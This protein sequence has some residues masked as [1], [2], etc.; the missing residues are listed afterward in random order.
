MANRRIRSP[1]KSGAPARWCGNTLGVLVCPSE[2]LSAIGKQARSDGAADSDNVLGDVVEALIGA[3]YLDQGLDVATELIHRLFDPLIAESAGLGAGLDWK[4]SL[5][6][7]CAAQGLGVPEYVVDES[8]PD[9]MKSFRARVRVGLPAATVVTLLTVVA[10]RLEDLDTVERAVAIHEPDTVFHLGALSN[11]PL[12]DINPL[13]YRVAQ[14]SQLPGFRDI[15]AGGNA[16]DNPAE[17]YDLV[18]G[19]GSPNVANLARGLLDAQEALART[20]DYL[21][22]G[23]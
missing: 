18:S 19:L 5:Q 2:S 4:T 13:L 6:E 11:D 10:G 20:S 14:G 21:S 3:L 15:T 16:I 23:G 7:L 22:E 8:G 9:H 17:G 12:G 1:L